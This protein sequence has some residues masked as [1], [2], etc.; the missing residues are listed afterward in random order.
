MKT[1]KT[2]TQNGW[3]LE[4]INSKPFRAENPYH[5]RRGFSFSGR[6]SIKKALECLNRIA[7]DPYD[8]ETITIIKD[9]RNTPEFIAE[10]TFDDTAS[11]LKYGFYPNPETEALRVAKENTPQY[12]AYRARLESININEGGCSNKPTQF[13][14]GISDDTTTTTATISVVM[15]VVA[16]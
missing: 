1:Y 2:Q 13:R 12:K 4:V 15:P 16:A 5:R 6:W 8:T 14:V 7:D 3:T 9:Y 10:E 11:C